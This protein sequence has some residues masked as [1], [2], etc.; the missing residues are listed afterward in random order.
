VALVIGEGFGYRVPADGG[1]GRVGDPVKMRGAK[2]QAK[3]PPAPARPGGIVGGSLSAEQVTGSGARAVRAQVTDLTADPVIQR[4][5]MPAPNRYW[6]SGRVD[7][8]ERSH[9]LAE[10]Y[11]PADQADPG[12]TAMWSPRR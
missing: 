9:K 12:R 5:D 8:V 2:A 3:S 11:G 7:P 4:A 1:Q 10:P 6:P